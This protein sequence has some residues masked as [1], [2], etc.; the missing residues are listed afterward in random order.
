MERE[1]EG[2]GE[3]EEKGRKNSVDGEGEG[4]VGGIWEEEE[5]EEAG[6]NEVNDDMGK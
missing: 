6:E 1:E 2:G 5:R 4:K 3:E